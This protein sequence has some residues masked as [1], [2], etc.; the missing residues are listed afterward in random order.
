MKMSRLW[1]IVPWAAFLAL[2][3][4]WVGY[5]HYVAAQAETQLAAFV[6]AQRQAGG[7]AAYARVVRRGFPALMRLE[8]HE[9]EYAPARAGWRATSDRADLHI[10]LL[11]PAHVIASAEAPIVIARAGGGETRIAA[12]ALIASLET[13]GDAL[14]AAG[15]EGDDVTL[16]DPGADGLLRAERVVFNV[17][18]DARAAG[19]YQVAFDALNVTLPRPVRSFEQFGLNVAQLRAAIVLTHGAALLNAGDGDPLEPWREAGGAARFEALALTWGPLQASG[20]G[21]GGLDEARRL[22]GRLTLPIE[23]PGPIFA[24]LANGPRVD[25]SARRALALLAAGYQVS[26]DG[27]ELDVEAAEGVL[28]LEGFPVRPLPPVY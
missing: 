24:A 9:L 23:Q 6:A 3:L 26:G 2:A 5:W 12:Q 1:L 15:V 18:P 27:I 25:E 21:E 20:A 11:N 7:D 19:D 8:L 22:Q 13:R 17:R 28:R 16:D 14:A 4:A 10:D